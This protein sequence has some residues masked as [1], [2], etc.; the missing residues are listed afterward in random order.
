MVK[1]QQKPAT[2]MKFNLSSKNRT[3]H[4][5]NYLGNVHIE[6]LSL[7]SSM[8][9][10]I[11][12]MLFVFRKLLNLAVYLTVANAPHRSISSHLHFNLFCEAL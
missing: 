12:A 9:P 5:L 3:S 1:L 7:G 8:S 4:V 2:E 10:E 11:H 6:M